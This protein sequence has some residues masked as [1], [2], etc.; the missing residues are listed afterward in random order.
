MENAIIP[1]LLSHPVLT[2]AGIMTGISLLIIPLSIRYIITPLI[3]LSVSRRY[4]SKKRSK[5][6]LWMEGESRKLADRMYGRI[7]SILYHSESFQLSTDLKSLLGILIPAGEGEDVLESLRFDFSPVRFLETL[8]FA[9][10]DLHLEAEKRFLLRY[11]LKR[12]IKWFKPFQGG[13][14]FQRMINSIPVID[15]FNKK[16]LFTQ[17]FRL[18]LIPLIGLPGILLYTL[19]SITIRG[20]WA[21][22]IRYYY[23]HF[24]F[25]AGHYLIYLYGG[26]T[27]ALMERRKKFSRSEIVRKG[28]HYDRELSLLPD[29]EIKPETLTEMLSTY[30]QIMTD[31]GFAHDPIYTLKEQPRNI[32]HGLRRQVKGMF[33]RTLSALNHQF[34]EK[35]ENQGM[36]ETALR[37]LL[38]LPGKRYPG[39]KDPWMNYRI[40]Q[41]LNVSYRLLM[42]SL[43]RVYSNAPGSHFAMERVS[44][45]LIRQA[46]EFSRQPLIALLSRTGRNS[47]KAIKPLLHLRKLNRLR[48]RTTPMGVATLSMP[49]LGKLI[50]DRWKELILYRLGRAVIRYSIFEEETR[51]L[52]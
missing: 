1:V 47:Y 48:S 28:L 11:L 33:R 29:P 51:S 16:G 26:N 39:R 22:L 13:M 6:E 45:D 40:I 12:R 20:I 30:E 44:V 24:L 46:R 10:E 50:Q 35:E 38:E 15:F 4:R 41:G 49:L 7:R 37:L 27:V 34:T 42:I 52:P 18:I 23:T 14:K 9:Y 17:V 31:A 43:S 36:R 19:R 32:G 5:D 8:L 2:T 25:R 3:L 21:G